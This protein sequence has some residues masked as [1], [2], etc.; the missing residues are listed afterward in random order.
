IF[1]PTVPKGGDGNGVA[2]GSSHR[3]GKPANIQDILRSSS[4]SRSR[5]GS[6][7][8]SR[9]QRIHHQRSASLGSPIALS[10]L[11]KGGSITDRSRALRGVDKL[12]QPLN[13]SETSTQKASKEAV[14]SK[15]V[16]DADTP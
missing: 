13:V 15:R 6:A 4:P 8:S 2:G 16:D 11:G 1:M 7:N 12:H 5:S 14:A 9:R 3:I 10:L